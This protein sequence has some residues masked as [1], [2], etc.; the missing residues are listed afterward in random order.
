[1]LA[2]G[3]SALGQPCTVASTTLLLLSAYLE[4]LAVLY[5]SFIPVLKATVQS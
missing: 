1:M 4:L 5:Y 3:G 2:S